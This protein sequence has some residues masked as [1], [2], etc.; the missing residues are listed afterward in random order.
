MTTLRLSSDIIVWY[1]AVKEFEGGEVLR[2]EAGWT[3]MRCFGGIVG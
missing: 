3:V 2:R 1:A